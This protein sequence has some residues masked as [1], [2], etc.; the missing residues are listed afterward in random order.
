MSTK[1]DT[2]VS[3][4]LEWEEISSTFLASELQI[5]FF[6]E[7][8]QQIARRA[9]MLRLPDTTCLPLFI[10]NTAQKL[11]AVIGLQARQ[12]FPGDSDGK[13]STCNAG[14]RKILW[15][16]EWLSTPVFLSG[17]FHEQRSLTGYSACMGSQSVGH[18]WATST[19]KKDR[20]L[21][22]KFH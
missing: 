19:F 1:V 22:L 21:K 10:M 2:K 7:I 11:P 17:E 9:S 3:S 5:P 16:R 6:W 4:Y 15:R 8:L 20:A 13:E 14:V 12:S 18:N